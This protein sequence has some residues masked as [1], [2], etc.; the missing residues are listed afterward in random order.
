MFSL[1]LVHVDRSRRLPICMAESNSKSISWLTFL[2]SSEI[3]T[4]QMEITNNF[5][6][7][8]GWFTLIF[9]APQ[10]QTILFLSASVRVGYIICQT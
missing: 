4:D 8:H 7:H 10:A 9:S 5:P 1:A 3:D 2:L 6:F